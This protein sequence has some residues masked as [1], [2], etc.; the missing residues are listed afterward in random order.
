MQ[1]H[2]SFDNSQALRAFTKIILEVTLALTVILNIGICI[3]ELQT[4]HGM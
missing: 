4:Y 3:C 1:Q 2:G